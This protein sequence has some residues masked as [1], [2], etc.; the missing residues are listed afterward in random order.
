MTNEEI[1]REHQ[2]IYDLAKSNKHRIDAL[3]KEQEEIRSLTKSVAEM[4]TEQKH[5]REDLTEMKT[6]VKQIKEKPVK[7]W[8]GIVEKAFMVV[9]TILITYLFAQIGIS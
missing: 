4:V 8:D 2:Q 5:M 3:E 1:A 9:I 6:D 7:R